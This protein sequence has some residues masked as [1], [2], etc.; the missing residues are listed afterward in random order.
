MY[1]AAFTYGYTDT[2][3]D[4]H[5]VPCDVFGWRCV[6][7]WNVVD[8]WASRAVDI[9]RRSRVKRLRLLSPNPVPCGLADPR[10]VLSAYLASL[11][12]EVK[13]ARGKG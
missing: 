10:L 4:S 3:D 8:A 13:E 2:Y 9:D 6:K 1:R 5:T 12:D 11:P 7:C